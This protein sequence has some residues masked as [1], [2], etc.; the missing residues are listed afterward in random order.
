MIFSAVDT[1]TVVL[2]VAP[3]TKFGSQHQLRTNTP[4]SSESISWNAPTPYNIVERCKGHTH[5]GHRENVLKVMNIRVFQGASRV[6]PGC[7]SLC[8]CQVCVLDPSKHSKRP[9]LQICPKISPDTDEYFGM[10]PARGMQK[11]V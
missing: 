1:Q 7:F 9:D 11:F 10:A 6:F 8:P 5:K 4:P 2:P 3:V